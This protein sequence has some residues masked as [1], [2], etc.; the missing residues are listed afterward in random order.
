MYASYINSA[1]D[2]LDSNNGV[3]LDKVADQISLPKSH[4]EHITPNHLSTILTTLTNNIS[5]LDSKFANNII[6]AIINYH[7]WWTLDTQIIMVFKNF[8]TTLCSYLPKWWAEIS[9]VL[10]NQFT[11]SSTKTQY[12]H[13]L[14][15]YFISIIPTSVHSLNKQLTKHFPNKHSHKHEIVNYVSNLLILN[16]YCTELR[17]N[18]WSLIIERSIQIDVEL[19][20][21][22]DELDDDDSDLDLD[23]GASDTDDSD[24]SDNDDDDKASRRVHFA[25]GTIGGDNDEEGDDMSDDSDD[26]DD[27]DMDEEEN[28]NGGNIQTANIV[29]LSEKLDSILCMVFDNLQNTRND[30]DAV[31]LC[32]ILTSLFKS[33]VLPTYYTKSTQF[34]MFLFTQLSPEFMDSFLVT[35]VDLSFAPEESIEKRIKAL[36]YLSSY[37][38][39][40]KMLQTSQIISILNF[41]MNW[42]NK[43]VEERE[44]EIVNGVN[45]DRFKLFY[46]TFQVL[47]YVFCFRHSLLKTDDDDWVL[48]L[49]KFFQRMV[50]TKFNPLK[51]C[52][53]N[54]VLMFAKIAQEENVAYCFSI[55]QKNKNE[56]LKGISGTKLSVSSGD[57]SNSKLNLAKQQF[58]DLEGYFPFD[59]LFLKES[60]KEIR[61]YYI[62]WSTI[63]RDYESDTDDFDDLANDA[64]EAVRRNS[65]NVDD[66]DDYDSDS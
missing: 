50:I 25:V 49:D 30:D 36:Q 40:A 9:S 27:D 64:K 37:L 28:I 45:M 59:P 17:F 47:L 1:L 60:K 15:R 5:R 42:L 46:S 29:E 61:D 14:L 6:F 48:G 65:M 22:L 19:Q 55:I 32:N 66:D 57:S 13:E 11:L 21:E 12:H 63:S 58:V 51:F 44:I 43:F 26:S 16:D 39:R 53:E 24:D 23:D 41:L 33:H 8:I 52:N 34:I 62:E 7:K 56:R 31:V 18:I 35:L 4:P 20:N 10:I 2:A 54:V 3:Q 38:A